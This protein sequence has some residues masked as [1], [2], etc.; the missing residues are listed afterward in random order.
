MGPG[1][2][3]L[4]GWPPRSAGTGARLSAHEIA[5]TLIAHRLASP[6]RGR[7]EIGFLAQFVSSF[8]PVLGRSPAAA[9]LL[10]AQ[11]TDTCGQWWTVLRS[12]RK[13]VHDAEAV[14]ARASPCD[15]FQFARRVGLTSSTVRAVVSFLVS[16]SSVHE[17]RSRAM[18]R[19]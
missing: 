7:P 3:A 9:G 2:H 17:G 11:L 12:P 18:E 14:S 6:W 19:R 8:T 1:L 13:R 4:D 10:S 16:Y 15:R 5:S